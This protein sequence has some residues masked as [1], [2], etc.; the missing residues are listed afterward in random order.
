MAPPF[1]NT[2][3]NWGQFNNGL[4]IGT[5]NKNLFRSQG[6]FKEKYINILDMHTNIHVYL[7]VSILIYTYTCILTYTYTYIGALNVDITAFQKFKHI[8]ISVYLHTYI[9]VYLC[10]CIY[11][12]FF[13]QKIFFIKL[14]KAPDRSINPMPFCYFSRS[15]ISFK[16]KSYVFLSSFFKL[17]SRYSSNN[18][19]INESTL[20]ALP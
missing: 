13:L 15:V 19:S 2:S 7:Y 20:S 4:W 11:V 18:I 9:H 1:L 14:K 12:H 5:N 17:V 8:H 6:I 3:N 16:I 10:I